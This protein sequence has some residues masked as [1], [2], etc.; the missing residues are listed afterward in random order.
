MEIYSSL[1]RGNLEELRTLLRSLESEL[2]NYLADRC[3]GVQN[4]EYLLRSQN[5]IVLVVLETGLLLI[6]EYSHL[7]C[8]IALILSVEESF[9]SRPDCFSHRIFFLIGFFREISS[10]IQ[11][12]VVC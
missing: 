12:G 3:F 9:G 6:L 8:L 1:S 4:A 10:S 7:Q 2:T 11:L 5:L